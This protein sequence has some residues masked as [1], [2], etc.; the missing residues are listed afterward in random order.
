MQRGDQAGAIQAHERAATAVVEALVAATT[1]SGGN[2]ESSTL[3]SP[4]TTAID[5]TFTDG[6]DRLSVVPS[7]Q[8]SSVVFPG[9]RAGVLDLAITTAFQPA[10]FRRN[11]FM[12]G[13]MAALIALLMFVVVEASNPIWAQMRFIRRGTDKRRS[14][15]TCR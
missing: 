3:W 8:T 15:V 13:T 12:I 14:H 5:D 4:L 2:V 7:S 11:L 9:L 10:P 1:S 6:T